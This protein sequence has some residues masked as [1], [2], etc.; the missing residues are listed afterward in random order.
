M[1]EPGDEADLAEKA[2]GA[3]GG[4]EVRVNHLQRDRPV[5]AE[6]V[7]EVNRRGAA[8]AEKPRLPSGRRSIR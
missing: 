3:D 5:V 4:G 6:V 7:G 2:L 8:P 1:G